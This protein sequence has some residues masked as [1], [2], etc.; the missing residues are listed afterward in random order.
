MNTKTSEM[1]KSACKN[2]GGFGVKLA[3]GPWCTIE[4]SRIVSCDPIVATLL[5]QGILSLTM[6]P[7]SG[8]FVVSGDIKE[9]TTPGIVYAACKLLN[10]DGAWLVRFLRGWDQNT[11]IIITD[12]DDVQHRDE[13]S[14]FAISLAKEFI[15]GL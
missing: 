2:I 10:V 7:L 6:M 8:N 13:V 15:K 3:R 11:Q 14:G 4:G 9:P 5:A 12:K 1:I